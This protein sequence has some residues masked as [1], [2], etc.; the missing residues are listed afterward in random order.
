MLKIR[1]GAVVAILAAC[2]AGCGES[3][4]PIEEQ[5]VI[6]G[7]HRGTTHQLPDKKGFVELV[8]EPQPMDRRSNEPTA[9][10]AYFLKMDGKTPLEPAPTDV[11]FSLNAGGGGRGGRGHQQSAAKSVPLIAEPKAEDPSGGCRFASRP[12]PYLLE[13]IQGTLGA[14]ID[15]QPVSVSI[16]GAR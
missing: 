11:A 6:N 13:A 16:S 10:V 8:N 3:P 4:R 15:G 7:P 5:S 2:L 9:L 14:K 12:G 1:S